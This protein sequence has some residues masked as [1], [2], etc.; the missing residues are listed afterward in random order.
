MDDAGK[1]G[2]ALSFDGVNDWVT[3]ADCQRAGPDDGD[4]AVGVGVSDGARQ[5]VWRNVMIKERAGG[6]V[7]NLYSNADT[8]VPMVYVVRS[9]APGSRWMRAARRRC[10]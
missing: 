1:Y 8:N 7:Y 9:A 6:E 5:R 3:V 2:S 4:D 10:R